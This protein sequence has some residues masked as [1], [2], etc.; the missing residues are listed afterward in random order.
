MIKIKK[1]IIKVIK[2][3]KKYIKFY[4]LIIIKGDIE[5]IKDLIQLKQKTKINNIN[6]K[7]NQQYLRI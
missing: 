3:F 6:N 5:K 7:N 4:W 2:R 1:F